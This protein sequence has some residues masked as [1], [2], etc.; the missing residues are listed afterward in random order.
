M[1]GNGEKFGTLCGMDN[2]PYDFSD[3]DVELFKSIA[4]LLTF[5]LQLDK[6]N[7]N[8]TDLSVPI[9]PLFEGVGIL[10]LIGEIDEK[11]AQQLIEETLYQSQKLGLDHLVIELSGVTNIDDYMV[12]QLQKMTHALQLIGITPIISGIR[13]D[14]A[15]Q[16][17]HSNLNFKDV[18]VFSSVQQ[19]LSSLG[20]KVVNEEDPRQQLPQF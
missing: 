12:S 11:R 10:P 19:S 13:P 7:K 16:S 14:M 3:D 9:V 1:Y 4:S 18:K 8:I 5:V 6:A 17:V 2:K 15:M 20:L